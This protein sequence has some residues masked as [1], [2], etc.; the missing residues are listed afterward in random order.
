MKDR[1][2]ETLTGQ[3]LTNLLLGGFSLLALLLAA[4]GIYG[5]LSV[6]VSSRTTE[7]GI[8]LALGAKP[9][10]LV[11]SVL[12]EGLLLAIFGISAG[13][14]GALALTHTVASLLFEV[15]ATDP[16][17]FSGVPLLLAAVALVA[18]YVPALRASQ[19]DPMNALRYD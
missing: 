1:I 16:I 11:R 17:V 8:R 15:S 12:G 18:C 19:V 3:R 7:F 13:M 2:S 10:N 6:Y 4:V 5:V 14:V 9:G